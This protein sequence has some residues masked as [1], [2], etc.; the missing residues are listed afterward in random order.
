MNERIAVGDKVWTPTGPGVVKAIH[1]FRGL[2]G[3][4]KKP[5]FV[6]DLDDQGHCSYFPYDH[7][8]A[9]VEYE[10]HVEEEHSSRA[11]NQAEA[12]EVERHQE[13][14]HAEREEEWP[15]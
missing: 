11:E 3:L 6:V 1:P 12:L 9:L 13:A 10:I 7:I 15:A 2:R 14:K 4:V 8:E 5:M